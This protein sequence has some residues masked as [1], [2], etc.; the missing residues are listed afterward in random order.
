MQV[1]NK[2]S[3]LEIRRA[4][5]AN[6]TP[7]EIALWEEIRNGKLNGLK[8][9]RQH[10]IGNYVVDFYCASK[11][12]II[13][14]DGA[15]HN[16]TDQQEKDKLRDINLSE[17]NFKIMRFTNDEVLFEIEQVKVAILK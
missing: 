3:L 15:V 6:S 4:L 2:K 16:T 17:M 11:R 8:F 13:E 1:H 12:L 9:K 7:A 5:R 10:S 14:L